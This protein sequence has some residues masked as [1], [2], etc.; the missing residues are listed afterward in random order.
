MAFDKEDARELLR[1]G[2]LRTTAP[3]LAVLRVLADAPHPVSHK[4]VLELMGETDWDP[5]TIF[6]NLVKLREAGIAPVV[7]RAEGIDRYALASSDEHRHAHFVCD[8][9]G[10]VSC[11]PDK[12]TA[13]IKVSGRWA[14]AVRD[15][16]VQLRGECPDCRQ[17]GRA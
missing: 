8:D 2:G 1:R 10:K 7:S 16:V 4:E 15:A 5:A 13:S 12:V 9:C 3:R 14:K 11:L 17:A 6:R